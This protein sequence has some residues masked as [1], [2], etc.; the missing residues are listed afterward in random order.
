MSIKKGLGLPIG[1]NSFVYFTLQGDDFFTEAVRGSQPEWGFERDLE[2][3]I[4]PELE[5]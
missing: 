5:E 1:S 2:L 4:T 3:M